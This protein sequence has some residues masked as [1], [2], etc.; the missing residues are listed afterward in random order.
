VATFKHRSARKHS[1]KWAGVP[2]CRVQCDIQKQTPL[3]DVTPT[4]LSFAQR[5]INKFSTRR[6]NLKDDDKTENLS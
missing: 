2:L 4:L 1:Q 6:Q 5:Q 3:R